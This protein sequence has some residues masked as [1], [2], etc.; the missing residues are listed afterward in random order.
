[1][2]SN[3]KASLVKNNGEKTQMKDKEREYEIYMYRRN[4]DHG[5]DFLFENTTKNYMFEVFLKLELT[6]LKITD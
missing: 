5:V 2:T 6:N 1:M 4:H 3:D